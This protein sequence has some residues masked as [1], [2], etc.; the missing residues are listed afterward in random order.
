MHNNAVLFILN[1]VSQRSIL[2]SILQHQSLTTLQTSS[3]L[4]GPRHAYHEPAASVAVLS[5]EKNVAN[6]ELLNDNCPS[7]Q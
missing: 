2:V 4:I 1:D 3:G 7:Q 6:T 5:F